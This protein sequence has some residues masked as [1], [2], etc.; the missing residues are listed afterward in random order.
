[1]RT[2]AKSSLAD[3][4]ALPIFSPAV[5]KISSIIYCSLSCQSKTLGGDRGADLLALDGVGDVAL[6]LHPKDS[7]W[8]L[9]V[10]A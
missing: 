8:H 4:T 2:V 1:M 7:H 6:T 10:H 5:F 9:V 3:S